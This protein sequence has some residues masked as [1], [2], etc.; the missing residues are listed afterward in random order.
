VDTL[1]KI[2]IVLAFFSTLLLFAAWANEKFEEYWGEDDEE[3]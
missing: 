2:V 3:N 1:F